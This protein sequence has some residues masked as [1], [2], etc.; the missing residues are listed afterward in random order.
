MLVV[1]TA[2]PP[3]VSLVI[4]DLWVTPVGEDQGPLLML[5]VFHGVLLKS[6]GLRASA[7]LAPTRLCWSGKT[8]VRVAFGSQCI[9]SASTLPTHESV[10]DG[11]P[12]SR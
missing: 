9:D 11:G 4:V 12:L 7:K 5:V 1:S 3:A 2:R 6:I 10:D 8:F